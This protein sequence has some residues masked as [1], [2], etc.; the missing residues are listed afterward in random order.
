[1]STFVPA[2]VEARRSIRAF[3]PDAVDRAQ[4]STD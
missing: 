1:M 2:F 4:R 3:L